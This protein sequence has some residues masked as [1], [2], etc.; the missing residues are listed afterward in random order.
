MSG[1][2]APSHAKRRSWRLRSELIFQEAI[3]IVGLG[4][5]AS[6]SLIAASLARYLCADNLISGKEAE[7]SEEDARAPFSSLCIDHS[8]FNLHARG[9]GNH[10][11]GRQLGRELRVDPF[12]RGRIAMHENNL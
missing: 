5:R 10:F 8:Q 12:H 3:L 2:V 11:R 9:W 4:A 6:C 7:N 1:F